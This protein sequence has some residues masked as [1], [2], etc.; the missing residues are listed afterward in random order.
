MSCF[1]LLTIPWIKSLKCKLLFSPITFLIHAF[2]LHFSFQNSHAFFL[3]C[4]S[5]LFFFPSVSIHIFLCLDFSGS[6]CSLYNHYFSSFA[7]SQRRG[8]LTVDFFSSPTEEFE[9][10][11][12]DIANTAAWGGQL[13]VSIVFTQ[14]RIL[15]IINI[16]SEKDFLG[17]TACRH[18]ETYS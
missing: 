2:S 14:F 10:Y 9:K 6:S 5:F 4:V 13:E 15:Q 7:C 3:A 16:S 17:N 8:L 11:C 18:R 1:L 12:D